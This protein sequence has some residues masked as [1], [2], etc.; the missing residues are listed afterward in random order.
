MSQVNTPIQSGNAPRIVV[1]MTSLLVAIFAFQLNASM[2]SPALVTMQNELATT[3]AA[4]GLTQTVFFTAAALFSLFLPRLAD[5]IGRRKVLGSMLAL[6]GV[7]CLISAI[8]PDVN[9]LMIGRVLQGVS[10]PVVPMCLI[11]LHEEVTDTARYTRLMAILTSVNGGIAGVDAI[12]GGWLAGNFGFR[13]VFLAMALVAIVAVV[14]VLAF[15]RESTADDTP[16]MDWAGVFSLGIA[17]LATYLAINEIQKL[18][19]MSVPLVVGFIVVAVIAFIAFWNLEKRNPAPMVSTIYMKQ[20]R[21]WGL[22]LTT[23]LTMTGMFAVMN[24]VVPAIA[25]DT[26]LW[27]GMGADGVSFATLT[28]YALLG[29]VFG[30]ITGMLAS[31]FSYHAVLR[32]GLVVSIAGIL[33]GVFI[34]QSPSIPLLVA[35]SVV[36][37]ISYAGTANIMLN[38]LGIMLSPK[39]NPGYL[40][41]MNAGAFNLGAGLSFVV[42]YAVMGAVNIGGDVAAGYASSLITGAVILVF[43][44]LAS[45]LIPR[46][47]DADR[48]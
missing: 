28:P 21:T 47:E 6:T 40:P 37:G 38:G 19:A 48:S 41:G 23:L 9:I 13:S 15:T 30:P 5:L 36:L 24:G 34:A 17:F 3:E 7:G 12:L 45:F 31:K 32:C 11:M 8:A 16:K 2:L 33:F 20:R 39:D 46:P 26:T 10:G 4:I 35:I 27:S 1:L 42:L 29:L 18:A 14:L 43:A 44:L 25:Q 22:L